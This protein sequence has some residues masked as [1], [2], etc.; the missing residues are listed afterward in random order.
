MK[1]GD[2]P[3]LSRQGQI[4]RM[5]TVACRRPD[6]DSV[7]LVVDAD[8]SCPI[9]SCC[10]FQSRIRESVEHFNKK[11][12]IILLKREFESLFLCSILS[13]VEHYDEYGPS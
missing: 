10:D 4:E 5:I 6:G 2:I 13:I 8:D 12:G 11:I 9:E 1:V 7:L 3:K